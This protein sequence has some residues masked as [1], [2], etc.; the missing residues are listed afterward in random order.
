[1]KLTY[2]LL[3]TNTLLEGAIGILCWFFPGTISTLPGLESL[4]ESPPSALLLAMY[5]S[6]AITLA[7]VS[8]LALRQ[9]PQTEFRL[10]L[11]LLLFVFHSLLA[12][13]Q[14]VHNPDMRPGVIHILLAA[15][16]VAGWRRE[17]DLINII[18]PQA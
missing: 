12:L 17:K 15:G 11:L 14:F 10:G 16:F 13:S 7:L 9:A 4:A 8:A 6:A 18:K 2:Y 3:L 5:G 1:M